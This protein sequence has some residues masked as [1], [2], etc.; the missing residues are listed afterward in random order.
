MPLLLSFWQF[1]GVRS[2][3][4]SI[5]I[6][7]VKKQNI[8]WHRTTFWTYN[9]QIANQMLLDSVPC[10][11]NF[12]FFLS[13]LLHS[14]LIVT[15]KRLKILWVQRRWSR[16]ESCSVFALQ[17]NVSTCSILIIYICRFG[18]MP[19]NTF[20]RSKRMVQ[21]RMF[22]LLALNAKPLI[23]THR[24]RRKMVWPFSWSMMINAVVL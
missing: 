16:S 11:S 12:F 13:G 5:E 6:L 7:S 14:G 24:R 20:W 4:E 19:R 1:D 17:V 8:I 15:G 23:L 18:V 10:I 9:F 22:L 2:S 21:L 3:F